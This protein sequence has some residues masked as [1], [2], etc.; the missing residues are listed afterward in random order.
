MAMVAG[1]AERVFG[2]PLAKRQHREL[3]EL[4]QRTEDR[5]EEYT[6]HMAVLAEAALIWISRQEPKP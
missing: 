2:N 6:R 1:T 3:M 4:H 5:L